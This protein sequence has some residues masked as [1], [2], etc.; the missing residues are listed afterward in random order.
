MSINKMHI[1]YH[2]LNVQGGDLIASW[3]YD[4]HTGSTKDPEYSSLNLKDT[5]FKEKQAAKY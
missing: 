1:I 2:P 5:N 3:L 4:V